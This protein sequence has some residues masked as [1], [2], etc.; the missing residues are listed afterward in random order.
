MISLLL[1]SS[2]LGGIETHVATLAETLLASGRPVEIL[3]LEDHGENSF[4]RQ[5]ESRGLAFSVLPGGFPGVRR[6]LRQH[7][8]SLLHTHG[9]KAGIIGRTA[10]RLSRTPVVSTFHAG[11]TGRF[12][13][14]LYQGLDAATSFLGERIAVSGPIADRL[15]FAA[16]HIPN[17][18]P[19]PPLAARPERHP[20]IGFV[21][22]LSPEKAPDRFCAMIEENTRPSGLADRATFHVFGDGPM[23]GELTARYAGRVTFH[24]SVTDIAAMWSE[25]DLVVMPS[26]AEGLPM[27]ALEAI[28]RG[29]PVIASDVGA[30]PDVVAGGKG[31]WLIPAGPDETCI[32]GGKRAIANWLDRSLAERT[33]RSRS[34]HLHATGTFSAAAALPLLLEVYRRAG[35]SG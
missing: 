2:G 11:E 32:E 5:L 14:N 4:H 21:G 12:P 16:M 23:R 13:V 31:G 24:G 25:L 10:A 26:R 27:A 3:F 28:S 34:A 30:L 1:D 19:V 22:R 6:Y 15:P 33:H 35:Y 20:R 8:C 17:F 29:I 9:Y 7:H 18:V